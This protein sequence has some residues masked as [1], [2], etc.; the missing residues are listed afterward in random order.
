[1]AV[2]VPPSRQIGRRQRLIREN[3]LAYAFLTP[4]LIL[5][6]VFGIFP[7]GFAFF[8]SLH[9]WRR[10]PGDYLG[11]NNYTQALDNFAYVLFFWVAL[12]AFGYGLFLLWKLWQKQDERLSALSTIIPGIFN[13]AAIILLMNWIAVLLPII[14]NIPQRIRGQ[15]RV[16]GLFVSQLALSFQFPEAVAAGNP[17][18]LAT[19]IALVISLIWWRRV[20]SESRFIYFIQA[21]G[22]ALAV[23]FSGLTLQL[24]ITEIQTAVADA[25]SKGESLPIWSLVIF[26]SAGVGLIIAAYIVW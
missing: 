13:A 6:F 23:A 2:P 20:Q 15:E 14:L 8:V 25:Q 7:V 26:I 3:L 11:L 19:V 24:T 5:L 21:T 16:A 18:L 22:A 4:A 17:F 9:R 12:G 10:F 1:M